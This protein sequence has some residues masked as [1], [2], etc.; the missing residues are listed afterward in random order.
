MTA[1]VM[2]VV[3][4]YFDP[5]ADEWVLDVGVFEVARGTKAECNAALDD[6]EQD[7]AERFGHTYQP[8]RER[9]VA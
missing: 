2:P 4:I 3:G 6:F 1:P 9:D 5:L 7:W 8:P